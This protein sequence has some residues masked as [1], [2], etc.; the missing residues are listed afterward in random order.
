MGFWCDIVFGVIKFSRHCWKIFLPISAVLVV[1]TI[2]IHLRLTDK[3][4]QNEATVVLLSVIGI[5]VIIGITA[6]IYDFRESIKED[7]KAKYDRK[8]PHAI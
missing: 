4:Y 7:R 2:E 8:H 3:S 5:T 6:F 1:A